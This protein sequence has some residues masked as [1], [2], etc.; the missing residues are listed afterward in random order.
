MKTVEGFDWLCDPT[1][2][3]KKERAKVCPQGE[4]E[5]SGLC[6]NERA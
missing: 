1:G 4:T 5:T 2:R 6:G 3:D